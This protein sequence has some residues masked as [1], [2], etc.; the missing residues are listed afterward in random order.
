[1]ECFDQA[2]LSNFHIHRS[3]IATEFD[4]DLLNFS[5]MLASLWGP[6][7]PFACLN[8]HY[9]G[10]AQVALTKSSASDSI[11]KMIELEHY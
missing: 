5:A 11:S 4:N 2:M 8:Y 3:N 10:S 7:R 6:N 9:A 1:M